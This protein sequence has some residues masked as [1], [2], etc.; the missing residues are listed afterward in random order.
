[1]CELLIGK[2]EVERMSDW[3]IS[4]ADFLMKQKFGDLKFG[5]K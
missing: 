3:N 4:F 2:A 5:L 1:M